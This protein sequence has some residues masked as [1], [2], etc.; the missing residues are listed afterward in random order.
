MAHLQ[1]VEEE[2][3]CG[4]GKVMFE[5]SDFY[6]HEVLKFKVKHASVRDKVKS[7][8]EATSY[9]QVDKFLNSVHRKPPHTDDKSREGRKLRI[10]EYYKRMQHKP[11]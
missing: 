6:V 5:P 3:Q 8:N 10:A 9:W 4:Y 7:F 1:E 2:V 11:L